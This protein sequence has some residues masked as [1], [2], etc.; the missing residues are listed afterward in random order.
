MVVVVVV[1]V[2]EV[3][4]ITRAR[5]RRLG[6]GAAIVREGM[7]ARDVVYGVCE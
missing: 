4:I 7:I 5:R 1:V 6:K 2:Y 3:V